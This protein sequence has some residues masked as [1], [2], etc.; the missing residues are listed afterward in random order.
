MMNTATVSGPIEGANP[1]AGSPLRDLV[2][3]G[4]VCEEFFLEGNTKA[5][6]NIGDER[7]TADGR[8]EAEVFGEGAYRTRILVV[9]PSDPT[10]FNGTVLLNWQNVS[11]GAEITRPDEDE[12]YRGYAWVGV[13]AQEISLYG[14]PMGM[15]V[16]GVRPRE[17]L[18]DLDHERYGTLAHPGDAGSF[19]IFGQ[20]ARAVRPGRGVAPDPL[21]GLEVRRVVAL[22]GSQSAMRLAAYVNGIHPLHQVIDGFILSV[23]E[24][25]APL[26]HEGPQ[27]MGVRTALR[28]DLEVPIIVVNSEFEAEAGATEEQPDHDRLRVW[29]V[30]GTGHGTR[31]RQLPPGPSGWLSNPLSWDPVH[32]AAFREMQRWLVDAA[33]PTSQPRIETDQRGRLV[34][35]EHGNALGGVRLPDLE[36]PVGTFKGM[37]IKMGS[38]PL[39]GGFLPMDADVLGSL[40]PSS[41]AFVERWD[42][43][44][45]AMLAARTLLTEDAPSQR[46]RGRMVAASLPRTD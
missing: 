8:W 3:V 25:R 23:W 40:Y 32:Q 29:E 45:A 30:T 9:R 24:G 26:L 19:D 33:A 38:A 13:S 46:E 7:P 12:I 35:D 15:G 4:Y 6:E 22:G 27:P 17:A 18:I 36:L 21:G 42:A 28:D 2:E 41:E 20:A 43:A 5:Y 11:A 37:S 31:R 10:R 14:S 44:V 39:F 34:R 1:P 16:R